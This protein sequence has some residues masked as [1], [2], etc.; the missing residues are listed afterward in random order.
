M[1]FIINLLLLDNTSYQRS[2]QNVPSKHV[3]SFDK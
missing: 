3:V 1:L 2:P